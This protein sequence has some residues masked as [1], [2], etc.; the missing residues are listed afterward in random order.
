LEFGTVL[1][2][3]EKIGIELPRYCYHDK[4]SIAGNCRMCL[5]E[6]ESSI[7]PCI[8]CG[9]DL[10]PNMNIYTESFLVRQIQEAILEFL[11]INHPLD[12]PICDQGGEC[13]LQDLTFLYGTDSSKFFEAKRYVKEKNCG[14]FIK[15]S[16]NRCIQCTRCIRFMDEVAQ[17]PSLITVGRGSS[18]EIGMYLEKIIFSDLS[19]NLVDICPVAHIHQ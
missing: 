5:Y 6:T 14:P 18:M 1:Q 19:G 8:A 16:M 15:T 12:C 7:K 2:A 4:L 3:C 11:L 10:E 17:I 13:D 9:Y